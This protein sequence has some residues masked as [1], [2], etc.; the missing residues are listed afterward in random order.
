MRYVKPCQ[1]VH[2]LLLLRFL[3]KNV[4]KLVLALWRIGSISLILIRV[5]V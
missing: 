5:F 1:L 4:S 2:V 3:V